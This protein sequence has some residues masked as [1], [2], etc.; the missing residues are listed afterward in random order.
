MNRGDVIALADDGLN[1]TV[2]RNQKAKFLI[3]TIRKVFLAF[4]IEDTLWSP[5]EM[6]ELVISLTLNTVTIPPNTLASCPS[7]RLNPKK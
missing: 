6:L 2:K 5:F 4:M 1:I 3:F 7:Q